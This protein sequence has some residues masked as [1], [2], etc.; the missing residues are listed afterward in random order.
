MIRHIV[1]FRWKPS[2]TDDVRRQWTAGLDGLQEQIPGLLNLVH[3]PDVLHTDKSWDHVII[4]DFSTPED[5]E[6]YNSHPAHEAIKPFSL[7]NVEQLA[8]VDFEL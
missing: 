2:F 5:I 3:G 4:A 7:P 6:V 8:Y 1:M